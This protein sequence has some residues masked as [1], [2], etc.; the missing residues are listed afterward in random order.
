MIGLDELPT[1]TCALFR[2]LRTSR[3]LPIQ[4][5]SPLLTCTRHQ[6]FDTCPASA[7]PRTYL[8]PDGRSWLVSAVS[9][10]YGRRAGLAQSDRGTA[11]PMRIRARLDCRASTDERPRADRGCFQVNAFRKQPAEFFAMELSRQFEVIERRAGKHYERWHGLL[12]S[13]LVAGVLRCSPCE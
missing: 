7:T 4:Q 11:R 9:C 10:F 8:L 6:S 1:K 12:N 13:I 5:P 2:Y 3:R